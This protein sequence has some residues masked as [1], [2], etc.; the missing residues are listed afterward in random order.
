MIFIKKHGLSLFAIGLALTA[1]CLAY[2]RCK[3]LEADWM[4]ILVTILACIVTLLLGFNFLSALDFR[5]K[6]KEID[7]LYKEDIDKINAAIAGNFIQFS[8]IFDEV[9]YSYTQKIII[10]ANEKDCYYCLYYKIRSIINISTTNKVE[11]CNSYIQALIDFIN[12]HR[13]VLSKRDKEGLI[14]DVNT[15]FQN[16]RFEKMQVLIETITSI[17]TK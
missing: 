2:C 17:K 13:L 15:I 1:I 9:A 3:P 14:K 6:I 7:N 5:Q 8:N 10:D 16:G 4:T 11:V 12:H